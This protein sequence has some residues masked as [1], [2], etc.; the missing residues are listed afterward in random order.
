MKPKSAVIG[1]YKPCTSTPVT[2]SALDMHCQC[3]R[4]VRSA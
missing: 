3:L 4:M 1:Q 2:P